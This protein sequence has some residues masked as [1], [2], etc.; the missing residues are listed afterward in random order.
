[1]GDQLEAVRKGER[2][3]VKVMKGFL[4]ENEEF[5]ARMNEQDCGEGVGEGGGG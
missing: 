4:K 5:L 3:D 1:M 2:A